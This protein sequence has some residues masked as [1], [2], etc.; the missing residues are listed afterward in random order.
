[1]QFVHD[2]SVNAEK[3]WNEFVWIDISTH[4]AL[5]N[6]TFHFYRMCDEIR[7]LVLIYSPK[8]KPAR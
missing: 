8:E 6:L 3:L 7:R 1:M 5:Y 2:T 4:F